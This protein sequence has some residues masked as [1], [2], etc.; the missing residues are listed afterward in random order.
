MIVIFVKTTLVLWNT[1]VKWMKVALN[2]IS[3]RFLMGMKGYSPPEIKK[4]T[5]IKMVYS[6]RI[7]GY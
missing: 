3:I 7:L 2:S 6:G 1:I 4:K 5:P